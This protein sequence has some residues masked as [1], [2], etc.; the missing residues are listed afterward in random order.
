MTYGATVK[1]FYFTNVYHAS[2]VYQKQHKILHKATNI[3][4][5]LKFQLIYKTNFLK[6]L[7][8]RLYLLGCVMFMTLKYF[9]EKVQSNTSLWN[10]TKPVDYYIS[11]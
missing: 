7:F 1:T 8:C 4:R 2:M 3:T 5:I 6:Y 10:L 9:I 11:L